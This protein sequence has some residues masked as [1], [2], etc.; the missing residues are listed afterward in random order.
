[1]I[2]QP[3]SRVKRLP[4]PYLGHRHA[5]VTQTNNGVAWMVDGDQVS[6]AAAI[7]EEESSSSMEGPKSGAPFAS[8]RSPYLLA[9][10]QLPLSCGLSLPLLAHFSA[11][12]A[13]APSVTS[14]TTLFVEDGQK[15]MLQSL[16]TE[17]AKLQ[18]ENRGLSF[19]SFL[20][21]KTS[22]SLPQSHQVS[23]DFMPHPISGGR[24][25]IPT[26]NARDRQVWFFFRLV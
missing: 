19:H 9:T 11:S 14:A 8:I 21:H 26:R 5:S 15:A 13:S 12:T 23:S 4:L 16:Y 6:C 25:Q 24:T 7:V 20:S 18:A 1:M 3:R 10:H 22:V 17:V 2:D